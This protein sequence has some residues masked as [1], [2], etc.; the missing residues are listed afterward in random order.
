MLE[1]EIPVHII[2]VKWM[3]NSY[4]KRYQLYTGD[5]I[6]MNGIKQ[7][8]QTAKKTIEQHRDFVFVTI[9]DRS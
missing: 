7:L 8:F 9:I 2:L 6:A 1:A 4:D 3:E 5:F